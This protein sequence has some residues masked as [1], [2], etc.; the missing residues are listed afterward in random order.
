MPAER[1]GPK[2]RAAALLIATGLGL[3][4]APWV[5]GT[6]GSIPGL[7]A[8]WSLYRVGGSWAVAAG[9]FTVTAAG[10]WAADRTAA[11]LGER[12]PGVVVVDEIAGQMMTLLF[13][14]P[15]VTT[16]AAGFVLFRVLDILKPFPARRLESLP[17]GSGIMADDLAAGIY[18]N[19]LL[20]AALLV[21]P[22]W[23]AAA[24]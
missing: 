5:P 15:S 22:A 21:G 2:G 1:Q 6:V 23:A 4:Y 20:Q 19:V 8:G 12:D 9:L 3:G 16:L 7:L 18:A 17:G 13:V 11:R 14:R 24:L 10:V